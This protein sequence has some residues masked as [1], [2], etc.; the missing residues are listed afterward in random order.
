MVSIVDVELFVD[1][2]FYFHCIKLITAGLVGSK[3]VAMFFTG[4]IRLADGTRRDGTPPP[5]DRIW[6]GA[7][8]D[9]GGE[10]KKDH[11][12]TKSSGRINNDLGDLRSSSCTP[13]RP[14]TTAWPT[15]SGSAAK[16]WLEGYTPIHPNLGT[17][18]ESGGTI[19]RM[20]AFPGTRGLP[21][22]NETICSQVPQ[23]F[24]SPTNN[25]SSQQVSAATSEASSGHISASSRAAGLRPVPFSRLQAPEVQNLVTSTTLPIIE[26]NVPLSGVD[27]TQFCPELVLDSSTKRRCLQDLNQWDSIS[28]D[29]TDREV[30]ARVTMAST[31]AATSV[32]TIIDASSAKDLVE[33]YLGPPRGQVVPSTASLQGTMETAL[34]ALELGASGAPTFLAGQPREAGVHSPYLPRPGSA[35]L[36]EWLTTLQNI[37]N[38]PVGTLGYCIPATHFVATL[39]L[40]G[41]AT[42]KMVIMTA[43]LLCQPMA[44]QAM[45]SNNTQ[46]QRGGR[47][48]LEPD[49]LAVAARP[50]PLYGYNPYEDYK[51]HDI[52]A[53]LGNASHIRLL[54]GS[55]LILQVSTTEPT[56]D[57]V[58]YDRVIDLQELSRR[59]HNAA[60]WVDHALHPGSIGAIQPFRP[61]GGPDQTTKWEA[62]RS[63]EKVTVER[64]TTLALAFGGHMPESLGELRSLASLVESPEPDLIW[65]NTKQN[66][67]GSTYDSVS[68]NLSLTDAWILPA[69]DSGLP[70]CDVFHILQGKA[71][72]IQVSSIHSRYQWYDQ[73]TQSYHA[74][75]AW[76]LAVAINPTRLTCAIFIPSDPRTSPPLEYYQTCVIIR[77]GSKTHLKERTFLQALQQ[78]QE[79]LQRSPLEVDPQRLQNVDRNLP[80]VLM[81]QARVI[82]DLVTG[83]P[84]LLLT[85]DPITSTVPATLLE[86]EDLRSLE[87]GS[88][89]YNSPMDPTPA[90][91]LAA[92]AGYL[93][94]AAGS[95]VAKEITDMAVHKVFETL[96]E[97]GTYRLIHPRKLA[98]AVRAPSS[99]AYN[100]MVDAEVGPEFQIKEDANIMTLTA[101]KQEQVLPRSAVLSHEEIEHGIGLVS[102]EASLL[103]A[104]EQQVLP[105]I[106]DIGLGFLAGS[107]RVNVAS[108][109]L[110]SI[111][112]S[113][114][115][116]VASYFIPIVRQDTTR[117]KHILVGLPSYNG[118]QEG[119][120]TV[121]DL[122]QQAFTVHVHSK[123]TNATRAQVECALDLVSGSYE[124]VLS[125]QHSSCQTKEITVPLAQVLANVKGTRF[126]LVHAKPSKTKLY[127]DCRH[128]GS[129]TW[130][131][132]NRYSL[133]VL[134]PGCSLSISHMGKLSR[135]SSTQEASNSRFIFL[136]GWET[137]SMPLTLTKNEEIAISLGSTLGALFLT[138]LILATIAIKF[139]TR[140]RTLTAP[141]EQ[142]ELE[143]PVS[144][145]TTYTHYDDEALVQPPPMSVYNTRPSALNLTLN[146][147]RLDSQPPSSLVS[148]AA[149][150]ASL[151][152]VRTP[153]WRQPASNV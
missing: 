59:K 145:S 45:A 36:T 129:Q 71:V 62:F 151:G 153:N 138:T 126:L 22:K 50:V 53:T 79:N 16:N 3:Q 142:V 69:Q 32:Q 68:Y 57:I 150:V 90:A 141:V 13:A 72:L 60:V 127:L 82:P 75:D 152:Q 108:G 55:T 131:L 51:T 29:V 18:G 111:A 67:Q 47:Y 112:R 97:A 28:V 23:K 125:S 109:G 77:D 122:P 118:R 31:E 110:V 64:C 37:V 85:P 86:K 25:P 70:R 27:G 101:L 63:P 134:P 1:I 11:S 96:Q 30:P 113:N 33:V 104:L 34:T 124:N 132:E 39:L 42:V 44:L 6:T 106:S 89:A 130:P 117:T 14:V 148:R 65:M 103:N 139:R 46:R 2:E 17:S 119:K 24:L 149:S 58:R 114:S 5:S 144:G 100:T 93:V 26:A 54:A 120:A 107:Q 83:A 128:M 15:F 9:R 38:L 102:A 133:F 140:L 137:H 8:A 41:S 91:I 76:K 4:A 99:A 136:A 56:V 21:A 80:P 66:H 115:A 98:R 105:L 84:H 143:T 95:I 12:Y 121:L 40:P 10:E 87:R 94:A 49:S 81:E 19:A 20:E 52:P 78:Q 135:F 146:R 35:Q 48:M 123:Q 116:I 61:I 92:G 88:S 43:L 147:S 74:W 73:P 7:L